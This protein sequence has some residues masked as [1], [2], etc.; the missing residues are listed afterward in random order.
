MVAGSAN[1]A[2]LSDKRSFLTYLFVAL[3]GLSSDDTRI[4]APPDRPVRFLL[5]PCLHDNFV[6][7][8]S[9]VL[10]SLVHSGDVFPDKFVD[11]ILEALPHDHL[12][13]VDTLT[14]RRFAL[15]SLG[16]RIPLRL[17]QTVKVEVTDQDRVTVE[18]ISLGGLQ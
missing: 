11:D 4:E 16:K 17:A 18:H 10:C 1:D 5:F 9:W 13:F 2:V 14:A 3:T 7:T 8:P 15:V 6:W 12:L